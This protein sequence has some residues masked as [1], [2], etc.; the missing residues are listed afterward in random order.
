MS[1]G[2]KAMAANYA[3]LQTTGHNIA[4]ANTVGYSRQQ[5]ELATS[6]GQFTGAGFFGRGVDVVS[7][8]R[9]HNDYLTREA[10]SAKSLAGMDS[11]RLQQLQQL[12]NIFKPGEMGLGSATSDLMNAL[13]DLTSQP[14]DLATRQVVLAR[15]PTWRR[16][17]QKPALRWTSCR[18]ARCPSCAR[19]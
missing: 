15:G 17:F 10:A 12:E 13:T 9:A 7:V 19:R 18:P 11:A 8:T 2:I 5:A 6:Q 3:A 16:A 1:L 4:N 14:A